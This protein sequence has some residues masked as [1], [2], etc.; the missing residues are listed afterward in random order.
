M[1]NNTLKLND[2]TLLKKGSLIN[3]EWHQGAETFEVTNP[4]DGKEICQVSEAVV[5]G[6][7][8]LLEKAIS[9]AKQAQV[10]WAQ[11]TAQERSDL[12]HKW[13]D[14]M[15]ANQDDLA[16]I[17]TLEQGKPL[18]ESKGEIA[19]GASYVQWY[20]EEAKRIYGETIPAL[21]SNQAIKVIKQPIGVVAAITPWNFPNSMLARKIAPAIAAGNTV[22][23]RP[24]ELT[25]LSALALG[26]LAQRA[27][28]PNGV[29]NIIVSQQA[30]AVGQ[31]FT[32]QEDIGKFSFTGS[33][34]VGRQL[35]KQASSTLKKVSFELGGNAPFIVFDDADIDKAVEGAIQ[36]KFRNAGQTC[37][38][39]N[40]ILVDA[41]KHDEFVAKFVEKTKDLKV[42][43]GLD[44]VD[45]G[46]LIHQKA[47]DKVTE[48]VQS[49]IS[50]GAK[51]LL[52]SLASNNLQE[53]IV[54]T[55]VTNDM[56][57]AQQ[58][59][60]GPVAAIQK[61]DT[62]AQAI[63]IA[64]DTPFGLAAYFYSKD[65]SRVERV[66]AA[67][68]YGMVGINEG[69]ISNAA[70]PFGGIKQSGF[71]REGSHHGLNEYL[72]IKYLCYKLS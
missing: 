20:A 51:P 23:A 67:L 57:I 38:C 37:I 5:D 61:F 40:R 62:E 33:T 12:M 31:V 9:A 8:D 35:M 13:F 28:I 64:N 55:N 24:T 39:V 47:A 69:L 2:P 50:N 25:P 34:G 1:P 63:K 71:G 66:A 65:L 4:F 26:E 53:P 21:N 22:V 72:N 6:N 45:I 41:N 60:F 7:E 16:R 19:Y 46:P 52:G 58:E 29:I 15:M 56:E 36:A 43:N 30:E 18:K 3:G 68:K 49:A 11:K 48:L 44:D 32:Q 27:G 42:G 14:L 54:L 59:I 17:M 10:T 70:A